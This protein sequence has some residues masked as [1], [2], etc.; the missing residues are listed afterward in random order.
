MPARPV[1]GALHELRRCRGA[2]LVDDTAAA[3][4]TVTAAP[5]A[6]PAP[7]M[8]ATADGAERLLALCE[9]DLQDL[10]ARYAA[11]VSERNRQRALLDA[12]T[13]EILGAGVDRP[14]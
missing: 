11:V 14:V 3:H 10:R 4:A 9:A 6:A 1:P 7:A 2:Q 5:S 8:R 13:R 12:L